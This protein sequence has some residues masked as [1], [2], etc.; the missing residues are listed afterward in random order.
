MSR[1]GRAAGA[2]REHGP[3]R[4]PKPERGLC[5]A[6][7]TQAGE[8]KDNAERRE[9]APASALRGSRGH[10]QSWGKTRCAGP[11]SG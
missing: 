2:D 1:S 7:A 9:G 3:E 6:E 5:A 10:R 4:A 11:A 8:P